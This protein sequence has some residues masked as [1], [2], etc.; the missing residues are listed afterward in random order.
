LQMQLHT[1]AHNSRNQNRRNSRTFMR[2]CCLVGR[3]LTC[4]ISWKVCVKLRWV[5]GR[6]LR[7]SIVKPFYFFWVDDNNEFISSVLSKI[8]LY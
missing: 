3:D 4:H 1:N 6:G 2:F 5:I 8:E 7:V